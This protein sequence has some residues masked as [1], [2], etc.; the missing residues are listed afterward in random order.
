MI[1]KKYVGKYLPSKLEARAA[2][3]TAK[4]I[5]E[6]RDWNFSSMFSQD[7]NENDDLSENQ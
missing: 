6:T 2:F 4:H 3:K 1:E 7:S 5:V